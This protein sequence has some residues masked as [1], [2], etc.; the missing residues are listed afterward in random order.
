MPR[1]ARLPRP[2]STIVSW[3]A[4]GWAAVFGGVHVYWALG[5]GY[6]LPT[7]MRLAEHPK[8]FAATLLAVPCCAAA[9]MLALR[10]VGSGG[11]RRG[12]VPVGLTTAAAVFFA[13]HSAPTM[14]VLLRSTLT[15]NPP[16]LSERDALALHVYEPWWFLGAVLYGVLAALAAGAP[17]GLSQ[18]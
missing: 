11:R 14:I 18:R 2:L 8:L 15:S 6:G 3:A 5:G 16:T 10:V 4:A 9:A 13:A 17:R 1:A 7:G 12:W